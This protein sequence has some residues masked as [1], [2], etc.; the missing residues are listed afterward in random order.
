LFAVRPSLGGDFSRERGY[1][2]SVFIAAL[3]VNATAAAKLAARA[4]AVTEARELVANGPL[5]TSNPH[6]R[7][8]GSRLMIGLTNGDRM[9]TIVIQPDATDDAVWHVMTG[10]PSTEREVEAYRA[11][12]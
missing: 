9:L 5:V 10:W 8:P 1:R 3:I 4:I 7:V 11:A 6:P 2:R 12:G